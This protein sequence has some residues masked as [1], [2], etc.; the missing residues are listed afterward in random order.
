MISEFK[1]FSV[2]EKILIV[3]ELWDDI[4]SDQKNFE[5]SDAQ[6]EELD[7]RVADYHVSPDKGY[8]WEEVKNK[9]K[10]LK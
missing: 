7:R 3:E 8:T 2:A 1:K 10:S 9:I 4:A 5:L 6:K